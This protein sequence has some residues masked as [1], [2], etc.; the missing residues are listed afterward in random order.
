MLTIL[1][2]LGL[3]I[4]GAGLISCYSSLIS[5]RKRC[6]ETWAS[7]ENELR[8]RHDL[9]SKLVDVVRS[10][11]THDPG[12]LA[13]VTRLRDN[14]A[15]GVGQGATE[16]ELS[17]GLKKL[18]DHLEASSDLKA[19]NSFVGLREE[20]IQTEGRLLAAQRQYNENV[21]QNNNLVQAFPTNHIA[22]VFGF[23][24]RESFELQGSA[25]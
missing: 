3:A 25:S 5:V 12:L 4:F 6:T 18:T 1:F 13:D 20:L 9:I 23:K 16:N 15:S 14:C 10:Y 2:I 11:P 7:V 19:D 8:H 24:K 21:T 17:V 22:T